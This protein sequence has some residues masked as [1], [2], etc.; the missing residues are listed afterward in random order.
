MTGEDRLLLPRSFSYDDRGVR[1]FHRLVYPRKAVSDPEITCYRALYGLA[2]EQRPPPK[3]LHV[4]QAKVDP[5]LQEVLDKH[6]Q[7]FTIASLG[8][9]QES[10]NPRFVSRLR[11]RQE[12]NALAVNQERRLICPSE[13]MI[14]TQFIVFW[15]SVFP[16]ILIFCLSKCVCLWHLFVLCS[17]SIAPVFFR[18]CLG[19]LVPDIFIFSF[20]QLS[21]VRDMVDRYCTRRRCE[22]AHSPFL[23]EFGVRPPHSGVLASL[24]S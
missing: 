1:M 3:S 15:T 23:S 14:Q 6:F 5:G 21:V 8:R 13:D 12:A 22:L 2:M 7:T 10:A 11:Q 17:F 4:S 16:P 18:K 24:W 9:L 19:S 20:A